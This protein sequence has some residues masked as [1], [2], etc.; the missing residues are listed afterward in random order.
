M[1][2]LHAAIRYLWRHS[3]I[4]FAFIGGCGYVLAVILLAFFQHALKLDFAPANALTIFLTMIGTWLGNRYITFHSSRAHGAR[5]IAHEALKFLGAN[6]VGAAVN[7]GTALALVRLAP[8]PFNNSFVAQ[9][10]G[11]LAGLVF[12]FTLTKTLVFKV[13]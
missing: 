2:P 10:C 11:V 1:T 13:R 12:N 4:R 8:A 7:Y 9:A 5:N 3:L 6:A